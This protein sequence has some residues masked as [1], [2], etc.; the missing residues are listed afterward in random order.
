MRE[1]GGIEKRKKETRWIERIELNRDE[2]L[3]ERKL[4]YIIKKI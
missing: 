1:K 4:G 3:K 2:Y